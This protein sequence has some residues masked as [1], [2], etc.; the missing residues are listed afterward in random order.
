MQVMLDVL[1]AK[2][3]QNATLKMFM[4]STGDAI[5]VEASPRDRLW[6]IGMGELN[7]NVRDPKKWRGQNLLGKALMETRKRL[8]AT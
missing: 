2:F 6:G 7:P 8:R 3:S 5:I 1:W 4:L